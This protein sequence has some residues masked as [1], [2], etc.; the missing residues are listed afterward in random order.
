MIPESDKLMG[1][2]V[3]D[4]GYLSTQQLSHYLNDV[5]A[6]RKEPNSLIRL[7]SQSGRLQA[8]DVNN[9][10]SR[11]QEL[12]NGSGQTAGSGN[13]FQTQGPEGDILKLLQMNIL[14]EQSAQ[15]VRSALQNW[16][17]QGNEVSVRDAVIH[18]QLASPSQV[19]GALQAPHAGPATPPP[20]NPAGM[21]PSPSQAYNVQAAQNGFPP[22]S[23]DAEQGKRTQ[24]LSF[25]GGLGRSGTGPAP[26]PGAAAM[27]PLPGAPASFGAPP[28]MPGSPQGFSN[29]EGNHAFTNSLSASASNPFNGQ[30]PDNGSSN[31]VFSPLGGFSSPMP[32][33][34]NDGFAQT[35]SDA[36]SQNLLNASQV[37]P[38]GAPNPF[39]NSA[40]AAM[41]SSMGSMAGSMASSMANPMSASM[42]NPMSGSMANP[43][44]G[45]MASSPFATPINNTPFNPVSPSASMASG[46]LGVSDSMAS[47]PIGLGGP[48][49]IN[50]N[51]FGT[52][53]PAASFGG[54]A[55]STA[56][57]PFSAPAASPFSSAAS[58]P[59]PSPFVRPEPAQPGGF[60]GVKD[61]SPPVPPKREAKSS[62]RK[63][64]QSRNDKS[65]KN[66][67]KKNDRRKGGKRKKGLPLVPIAVGTAGL[68]V[69]L[70]VVLIFFV[71][72]RKRAMALYD[73][74]VTQ[75]Q[76]GKLLPALTTLDEIEPA[77][78][79]HDVPM[80]RGDINNQLRARTVGWIKEIETL[81]NDDKLKQSEDKLQETL[82][83][84]LPE[85][86]ERINEKK[87]LIK[88]A[89]EC[90]KARELAD[91]KDFLGALDIVRKIARKNLTEDNL[92]VEREILSLLNGYIRQ[93][94]TK[95]IDVAEEG[96]YSRSYEMVKDLRKKCDPKVYPRLKAINESIA[97]IK[98]AKIESQRKKLESQKNGQVY[99]QIEALIQSGKQAEALIAIIEIDRKNPG[100]IARSQKL[101]NN[102][103][104]ASIC[105]NF[106]QNKWNQC[107]NSAN[108]MI[109]TND[110]TGAYN[111]II[112]S[113]RVQFTVNNRRQTAHFIFGSAGPN[114]PPQIQFIPVKQA[115][116]LFKKFVSGGMKRPG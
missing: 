6:G 115:E 71:M 72:P 59:A 43:M 98:R 83:K 1:Q 57:S 108:N 109:K 28:P 58:A 48:S 68:I 102:T 10:R 74:A 49:G 16:Q 18:L 55:M 97:K 75:E 64:K 104:L 38:M 116:E 112:K 88:A 23:N 37:A 39:G 2:L 20:F 17:N 19:E 79:P 76:A 9:L 78:V 56:P 65:K 8:T 12:Q 52:P 22:Q 89:R 7:L 53:S 46:G 24:V 85:D 41:A 111:F 54:P 51:P 63:K 11:W 36:P 21:T 94:R 47:P 110:K 45:S 95:I 69:S 114:K 82:E 107:M 70:G 30:A 77:F 15:Q 73:K 4:A 61:S 105:Q 33:A 60:G 106:F 66:E 25:T 91:S 90:R 96:N 86:H 44:S 42:A 87:E 32:P 29:P 100:T 113:T 93:E 14:N 103:R 13:V 34:G 67:K 35:I 80:L 26:L 27:A 92:E 50:S 40:P 62:N 31:N 5:D 99:K 101:K 81:V 3:V 84:S